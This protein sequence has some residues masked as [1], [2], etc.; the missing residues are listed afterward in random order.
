MPG[1]VLVQHPG[2]SAQV[3]RLAVVGKIA[4]QH[5]VARAA[6]DCIVERGQEGKVV[7][8]EQARGGELCLHGADGGVEAGAGVAH[9]GE[10]VAFE[11]GVDVVEMHV[12]HEG[13]VYRFPQ[14]G[15]RCF[16]RGERRPA[17]NGTTN[18][19]HA[20]EHCHRFR[21]RP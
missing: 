11:A 4:G 18:H 9:S 12:R 1:R 13:D 7:F 10:G 19:Q 5:D 17:A 20:G 2:Q 16:L 6:C 15:N 3:H 14:C 21:N 8:I